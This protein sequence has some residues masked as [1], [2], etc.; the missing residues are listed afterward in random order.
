MNKLRYERPVFNFQKME[1]LEKVADKCWGNGYAFVDANENGTIE[2]PDEQYH[3]TDSGCEGNDPVSLNTRY[4]ALIR[5]FP[6]LGIPDDQGN[7]KITTDDVRTNIK[8][9]NK[10]VRPGVS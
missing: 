9:N 6:Q 4:L 2:L 8:S 10:Y 1:L 7:P 3:F 5:R